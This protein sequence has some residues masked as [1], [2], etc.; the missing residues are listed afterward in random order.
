MIVDVLSK[1]TDMFGA[2]RQV[3]KN[4]LYILI[5]GLQKEI[6]RGHTQEAQAVAEWILTDGKQ[7]A[8]VYRRLVWILFEDV[9]ST[10]PMMDDAC[11]LVLEGSGGN[12]MELIRI[13]AQSPKSRACDDLVWTALE[14]ERGLEVRDLSDLEELS[15]VDRLL[16]LSCGVCDLYTSDRDRYFAVFDSLLSDM[17]KTVIRKA[18]GMGA[19]DAILHPLAKL[20]PIEERYYPDFEP[21]VLDFDGIKS[22][23]IDQHTRLGKWV[24]ATLAK[25]MGV[26]RALLSET[27]FL[28]E[29]ALISRPRVG[30]DYG[31][32]LFGDRYGSAFH[33]L[34]RDKAMWQRLNELRDCFLKERKIV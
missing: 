17:E 22:Y 28:G 27:I 6:R 23:W 33:D 15:D 25:E 10:A 34:M 18:C 9:A 11:S 12:L 20:L 8:H 30:W 26:D 14:L 21:P 2:P 29:G 5:S 4:V 19:K 24:I 3:D 1:Q 16:S 32:K 31:V 7:R 13:M